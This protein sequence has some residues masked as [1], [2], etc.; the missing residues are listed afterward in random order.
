METVPPFY[1]S[2]LCPVLQQGRLGQPLAPGWVGGGGRPALS[3]G[4]V[5][6]K[7]LLNGHKPP[8]SPVS[9]QL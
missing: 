2:H 1:R 5:V 3:L 9:T 6:L 4:T 7:S 8:E